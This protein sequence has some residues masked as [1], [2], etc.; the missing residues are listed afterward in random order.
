[1]MTYT[2]ILLVSVLSMSAYAEDNQIVALC[3]S[4]SAQALVAA[5]LMASGAPFIETVQRDDDPEWRYLVGKVYRHQSLVAN[6]S[7]KQ[8][9]EY[10]KSF[11]HGELLRCHE[12]NR[13]P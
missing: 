5:R 8:K 13:L 10:A 6:V 9:E 1:M 11:A 12:E 7:E 4:V 3:D 2:K